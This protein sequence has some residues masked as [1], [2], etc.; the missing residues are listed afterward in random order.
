MIRL[1]SYN[2]LANAYMRPEYYLECSAEALDPVRRRKLLLE[3]IDGLKADILCLQEVEADL[4]HDLKRPG[5]FFQKGRGKPDGCAILVN[6]ET[7]KFAQQTRS[8]LSGK[9][10]WT[11]HHYQDGSG[12]G[13]LL[14]HLPGL[15]VG[16]THLKWDP[17]S[18]RPGFGMGQ[19]R[20]LLSLLEGPSLIC[21]DFNCESSDPIVQSCL[22]A[23]LS[24]AFLGV[25]PDQT[26][27]KQGEG[28]RI[29]F[30][31]SSFGLQVRALPMPDLMPEQ[32][33][34][35]TVEPSDHLP[36]VVELQNF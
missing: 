30:V 6:P 15:T 17:P 35:S 20:E 29:D 16:T 4:F 12:H 28:R 2:V 22:A 5:R 19:I 33:Q 34:P 24:D 3:R 13:A 23:G 14:L 32:I 27:V 31:L 9:L 10:H 1:V 36:L 21:G 7:Q 11:E 8:L 26:F 25:T 18:A